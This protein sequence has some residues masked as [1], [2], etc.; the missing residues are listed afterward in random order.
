LA[1]REARDAN[2]KPVPST[3]KR[4]TIEGV[5]ISAKYDEG[6]WRDENGRERDFYRPEG[7]KITVE[8]ADG[9]R[10]WGTCP[11]DCYTTGYETYV[12]GQPVKYTSGEDA[13]AMLKGKR[14]R[15]DARVTQSEKDAK[16]GFFKRPTKAVLIDAA[17]AMV[18][19]VAA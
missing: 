19:E 7:I 18:E 15:F 17:P 12:E 2:R 8:H 1:E 4:L 9:W 5:I 14:I 11:T 13:A 16:F 6:G 3:D 10:V